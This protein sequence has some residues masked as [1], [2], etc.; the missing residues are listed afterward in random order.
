M[1]T[2]GTRRRVHLIGIGGAGMSGIAHYLLG[3]GHVVSGSDVVRSKQTEDLRAH[4]ATIAIGHDAAH[5]GDAEVVVVSDAIAADNVELAEARRQNLDVVKRARFLDGL[6]ANKP[7]AVYV[8]GTHGKSTTSTMIATVLERAGRHPAYIIGADAAALGNVRARASSGTELVVEACEAFQSLCCYSPTIAVITNV[9]DDHVEHYGGRA[10]LDAAFSS[11]ASR[12][13]N[14]GV[15]IL[16]GDDEG[17]AHIRPGITGTVRSFGAQ[18]HNDV[19]VTSIVLRSTGSSFDVVADGQL[20]G[21]MDIPM[22]GRHVVM[23]ALAC[24]AACQ[25]LGVRFEDIARGLSDF[26]GPSRRWEDH[27]VVRGV[28]IIDDFAHH[29]TELQASIETAR[30]LL[31]AGQRL[32]LAFQPQLYSRTRRLCG[33]FARV[34]DGCDGAFLIEVD[35]GGER[36]LR[37]VSSQAILTAIGETSRPFLFFESVDDFIGGST[38]FL[39]DGDLL[40]IAGGGAIAGAAGRLARRLG[41]EDSGHAACRRL[42]E[43]GP[44]SRRGRAWIANAG[45]ITSMIAAYAQATPDA[46]AVCCDGVTLTYAELDAVSDRLADRFRR[47]GARRGDAIA[48]GLPPS[49][50]QISALLAALKIGAAYLPLD[51]HLPGD[52]LRTMADLAGAAILVTASGSRV[53]RALSHPAKVTFD[54]LV[55]TSESGGTDGDPT[56]RAE[57]G[58]GGTAYI[59]F[60]SGSTG[61]PKGIAISHAALSAFMCDALERF[62]FTSA[63]RTALNSS[64]NF[65]VSVG[66]ITMTLCAGG[67]L[68]IPGERGTLVGR[69]LQAFIERNRVTHLLATPSVL[70]TLPTP[71]PACLRTIIS[72]GE[73]CPQGLADRLS[74]DADFF[75]A[76]GPSEATIYSTAWKHSVGAALSIGT[77]L[78]HVQVHLLDEHGVPVTEGAIGEICLGGVGVCSGYLGDAGGNAD[79]FGTLRADDGTPVP[80]YRTGDLARW[81]PDGQID[82]AG[83][84][85]LQVKIRGNRVELEEIEFSLRALPEIRDAVVCVER[86]DHGAE[87]VAY[88]LSRSNKP[89]DHTQLSHELSRWLPDYM[90]PSL[91]LSVDHIPLTPAGKKHRTRLSEQNRHRLFRPTEFVAPVSATQIRLSGLWQSVLGIPTPPG[92]EDDFRQLGGDSLSHVML[93][94]EVEKVFGFDLPPGLLGRHA[95]L[96]AMASQ[97]DRLAASLTPC[98][99]ESGNEFEASDLYARL[100]TLSATWC[101]DKRTSAS[102][103]VSLGEVSARHHVFWC[104]QGEPEFQQLARHLGPEYRLYGMRSGHLVMDYTQENV[105]TLSAHYL[106]EILELRPQG[107]I[108]LGGNCQGGQIAHA[109][110]LKLKRLGRKVAV[111]ILLEQSHR[112]SYQDPIAFLFGKSGSLNPFVRFGGDLTGYRNAYPNGFELDLI[113]GEHGT[114]FD[115]PNIHF[116]ASQ[117]RAYVDRYLRA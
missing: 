95:T 66:E 89:V 37:A 76:Y 105:E 99:A 44:P 69:R 42:L 61:T 26:T 30:L 67:T 59:C 47:L 98:I 23:N 97:L 82:F 115:E 18:R 19:V 92:L 90:V 8:A 1:P 72:A 22:P 31:S 108:I 79:R 12:T 93:A 41:G 70:A 5:I 81:R 55:C 84:L 43:P 49:L 2:I 111:L 91:Y 75:N 17:I 106:R 32:M 94:M 20:L 117:I 104:L 24:T 107:P 63:S 86:N 33:E 48:L 35:G 77:P 9:D 36:D 3:E 50:D 21:R 65:D 85:D 52:R 29:P 38:A 13:G 56:T 74:A 40:L 7:V 87:L 116:L 62:G 14:T 109:V 57:V 54:D 68:V 16:N 96:A 11:F 28:R 6:C 25:T 51:D 100:R 10:G 103:I 73:T 15:V 46:I 34:I 113:P 4:G 71:T 102:L 39:R 45:S 64:L 60:T 114:Y 83:R 27:G 112:P 101:G 110:A 58:P 80:F 88:Y 78:S 53:D